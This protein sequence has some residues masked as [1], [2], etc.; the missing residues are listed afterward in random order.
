VPIDLDGGQHVLAGVTDVTDRLAAEAAVARSL[1]E[2][3]TLLKEIHHRVK[4]NLQIISSLLM[5]QRDQMPSEAAQRLLEESV[6][7]VRSMALIHQ[8]LYGVDSLERIE[9]GEYARSLA[10]SLQGALAPRVRIQVASTGVEVSVET[11]VPLGLILNELLTNAIKYGVPERAEAPAGA[12][13]A[14]A[15][16]YDVLVEIARVEDS[17]RVAVTDFGPGLPEGFDP[18]RATSLG[19]HL[20]RTLN[21]QLRGALDV[22]VDG[23]TRFSLV[24]PLPVER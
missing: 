24:C 13:A 5:L 14:D 10:S 19:L 16:P 22:R 4:N 15:P 11:A 18:A 21:R 6:L 3:E 12:R 8:Q 1:R 23:G 17:V 2:K 20:V 7:R 9:L